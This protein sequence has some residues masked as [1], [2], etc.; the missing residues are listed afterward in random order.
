VL[1][2]SEY[3]VFGGLAVGA[4]LT[5]WPVFW[6]FPALP[7]LTTLGLKPSLPRELFRSPYSVNSEFH[8]RRR[9]YGYE[10]GR[11][12]SKAKGVVYV[13]VSQSKARRMKKQSTVNG[14]QETG[15]DLTHRS[16]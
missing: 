13:V 6:L 8:R 7:K 15:G 12:D 10:Y 2:D 5:G 16:S 4:G 3:L 11:E 14:E 1:T 9:W